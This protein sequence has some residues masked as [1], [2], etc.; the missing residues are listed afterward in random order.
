MK[1]GSDN[2]SANNRSTSVLPNYSHMSFL[3]LANCLSSYN[4]SFKNPRKNA[5]WGNSQFNIQT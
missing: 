1:I 2:W 4:A 3:K 5:K